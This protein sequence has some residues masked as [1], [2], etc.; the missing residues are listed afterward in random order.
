MKHINLT[1]WRGTITDWT[2]LN[3]IY[4]GLDDSYAVKGNLRIDKDN[5][6]YVE[7]RESKNLLHLVDV[8]ETTT[9]GITWKVENGLIYLNGTSTAQVNIWLSIPTIASGKTIAFKDFGDM[10]NYST[11]T[12]QAYLAKAPSNYSDRFALSNNGQFFSGTTS[13][14]Y[15]TFQIFVSSGVT[16][17]NA[18]LKPMLVSGSTAPTI[19]ETGFEG[20][21]YVITENLGIVDLGSLNWEYI[22]ETTRFI[23]SG[24]QSVIKAGVNTTK[25]NLVCSIYTS[26]TF[27]DFI[28]NTPNM[29]MCVSTSSNLSIR[30]TTYTDAPTFKTAMS[31][32][33]LIY[34]LAIPKIEVVS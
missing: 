29:A 34:E 25:S 10:L 18:I 11:N 32:V 16:L 27:N 7:L 17:N 20:K 14:D 6:N 2:K 33:M 24:L 5:Y 26:E 30:N 15:T 1:N 9:N 22:S 3:Y 31:G 19:F 13:Y 23:S 12:I 8:A 28:N 21:K 4:G